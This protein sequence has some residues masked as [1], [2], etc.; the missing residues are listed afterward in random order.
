MYR[1]NVNDW[2]DLTRHEAS[3]NVIYNKEEGLQIVIQ[4][5]AIGS[6]IRL[7]GHS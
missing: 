7:Q 1:M 5:L 6:N 4:R 2:L 3:P